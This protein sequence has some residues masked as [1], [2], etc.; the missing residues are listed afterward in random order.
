[1]AG[2]NGGPW[3]GGGGNRGNGRGGDDRDRDRERGQRRPGE[4]Q[5]AP[6]LDDMLRKGQEQLKVLRA[7]QPTLDE[8]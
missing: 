7:D 5:Q 1:M 8:H 2:N 3:G 4:G 6:D